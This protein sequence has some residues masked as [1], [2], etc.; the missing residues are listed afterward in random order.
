VSAPVPL[1]TEAWLRRSVGLYEKRLDD[2]HANT[3]R[4]FAGLMVF[5]FIGG[6]VAALTI[7]PLTWAGSA[8][9]PHFHVY[10]AVFLGGAISA[11]PIFMAWRRP[12]SKLTRHVIAVGQTLWSALL[13]HLSG[14]RIETHFHV[15][16]SLAFLSFYRDPFVLLT[17][18]VVVAADHLI[19]GFYFPAS[20]Y[21]VLSAGNWRWVEHAAWVLFEDVFLLRSCLR[22]RRE[23]REMCAQQ[24]RAEGTAETVE[25][26]VVERTSELK[27]AR[28]QALEAVRMKSEFLANMSHEIRTPMNGV[29]GFVE[30]LEKT[31]L[32]GEQRSFMETVRSSGELLLSVL[33][34]ILDFSKIE[35]G[36]FD[37]EVLPFDLR[38]EVDTVIDL[39]APQAEKKGIEFLYAVRPNGPIWLRGDAMRLRQVLMNIAGNA[40]KFTERGEI[41][42]RA[43]VTQG[44]DERVEVKLEIR[45]TGIG[46]P[47]EKV[48]QLFQP[49]MQADG[50]T[51][52]RFG[53]TGLGLVIS[54]RLIHLMGGTVEVESALGKGTTFRISVAFARAD[55]PAADPRLGLELKDLAVLVV[56]DNANNRVLLQEF[57]LDL[58]CR[59]TAVDG[60][61]KALEALSA[62]RAAKRPFELALLD[63]QMP[64][65]DG[66]EL[67]RA[68]RAQP[69]H[70]GLRLVLLT[71]VSLLSNQDI[72]QSGFEAYLTKP[73]KQSLLLETLNQLVD[74]SAGGAKPAA[75][76]P[77]HPPGGRS[78]DGRGELAEGAA[79]RRV[80][81]VEDNR[82]NQ[83]LV[84]VMLERAGQSVDFARDG[85]EAVA[86]ATSV[87][88]DLILMDAQMPEMDGY[89]ATLAI[90]QAERPGEHV[91]IIALTARAM[92]GDR[93]RCLAAGM[94]DYLT[95]PITQRELLRAVQRWARRDP[96]ATRP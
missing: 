63:Y 34:D 28:D 62:A 41:S 72:K 58:G 86:A 9:S 13:I 33:N 51:T 54:R 1:E 44:A 69:E 8:S 52:R 57:L 49:F 32:D 85:R 18:T 43:D 36:R 3:D 11:L 68:I 17:A 59:P 14:G 21:G 45:D 64:L 48:A 87:R 77:A 71:S 27:V 94:D 66:L 46:I 91:P 83:R 38:R 37:L 10:L 96:E 53:G 93:E 82:V 73:I 16:G 78:S 24:A 15:F 56:D 40:V 22:G 5:Q 29:L 2:L 70:D 67:A 6:I 35:A 23:L 88:Y 31:N 76:L 47:P 92:E 75:P 74:P 60:G 26:Q 7:S 79:R 20:V 19:R 80:L 65:M 89:E 55:V 84:T 50:S 12:G 95:K 42:L 61:R 25:R 90:R 81:L 39:L 4:L 30:L